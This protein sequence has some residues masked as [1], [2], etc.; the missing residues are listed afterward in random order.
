MQRHGQAH[1]ICK[2]QLTQPTPAKHPNGT[3][4]PIAEQRSLLQHTGVVYTPT[5]R[6]SRLPK[7]Q[8]EPTF[9]QVSNMKPQYRIYRNPIKQWILEATVEG[10]QGPTEMGAEGMP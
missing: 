1:D 3:P 6:D 4:P 8:P 10:R 7:D 5:V 2:K 9:L